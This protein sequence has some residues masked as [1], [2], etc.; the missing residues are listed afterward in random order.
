MAN[1]LG[2]LG[3]VRRVARW[4]WDDLVQLGPDASPALYPAFP[5]ERVG[6]GRT[7][8]TLGAILPDRSFLAAT[9]GSKR[10]GSLE[11]VRVPYSPGLATHGSCPQEP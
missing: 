11:S 1:A 8:L 3:F 9:D 2:T 4:C 10:K 5:G 7:D 6:A